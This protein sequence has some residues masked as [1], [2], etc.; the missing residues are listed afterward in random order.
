MPVYEFIGDSTEFS[1]EITYPLTFG[2]WTLDPEM[3][4]LNH[5][6]HYWEI[7]LE[8]CNTSAEILDWIF[9]MRGKGNW[10]DQDTLDL[11]E[12]FD[13]I[14][15]PMRNFCSGGMVSAKGKE[16]EGGAKA[17]VEK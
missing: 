10:T 2:S 15:S 8:R 4:V 17:I 13:A 3:L 9:H 6:K 5:N 7:D 16:P 14:L 12:A 11:L 1:Y